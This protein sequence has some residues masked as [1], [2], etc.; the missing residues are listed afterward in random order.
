MLYYP[1]NV[2]DE[3]LP[4]YV[5]PYVLHY[6]NLSTPCLP[7]PGKTQLKRRAKQ[8]H[9][10]PIIIQCSGE[11]DIWIIQQGLASKQPVKFCPHSINFLLPPRTRP[12]RERILHL[13]EASV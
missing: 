9:N 11:T 10:V 1:I 7:S 4:G 12:E 8:R 5:A 13:E 3:K 2:E 6:G